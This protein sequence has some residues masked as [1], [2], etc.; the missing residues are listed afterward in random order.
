[1]CF[2]SAVGAEQQP[3]AV[4][5]PG[6]GAFDDPA[7]AA[8]PGAVR[9]PA[10]RYHGLHAALP[11]ETAVLVLV[12]TAIGDDAVGTPSRPADSAAD[13]RYPIEQREQFSDVVAVA[14]GECP[15]KRQPAAVYEEM[16]LAAAPAA[17]DRAGT[18]LR[19]PFFAWM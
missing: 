12:V 16:L 4:V 8:E 5:Q 1:L 17:V 9:S 11:D 3:S 18:R 7:I 6:E 2:V 13:R 10:A 14:A 19:A 15:G